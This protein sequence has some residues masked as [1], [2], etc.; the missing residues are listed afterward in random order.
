MILVKMNSFGVDV[1]ETRK[2]MFFTTTYP[3]FLD[4]IDTAE[5]RSALVVVLLMDHRHRCDKKMAEVRFYLPAN[6]EQKNK[7]KNYNEYSVQ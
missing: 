5:C 3:L 7:M 2:E 1:N 6:Q 4:L